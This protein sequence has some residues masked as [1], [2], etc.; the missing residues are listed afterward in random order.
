MLFE[1]L[2]RVSDA[3]D[4]LCGTRVVERPDA[5]KSSKYAC[6]TAVVTVDG[7]TDGDTK[8]ECSKCELFERAVRLDLAAAVKTSGGRVISNV[9]IPY[10]DGTAEIDCV[11]VLRSHLIS[12]ECKCYQ[13]VVFANYD[14]YKDWVQSLGGGRNFQFYSPVKQN[15]T[16]IRALCTA[17]GVSEEQCASLIVFPNDTKLMKLPSREVATICHKSSIPYLDILTPRLEVS[18]FNSQRVV[19]ILKGFAVTDEVL[20][21]NHVQYVEGR[22]KR[23]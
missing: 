23:R 21:K 7:S 10:R 19:Q 14:K 13:G 8:S 16:H 2:N 9:Y 3:I 6:S 5:Q 1:I 12:V 22:S 20:K 11:V 17:L 15:A 4:V 18:Y